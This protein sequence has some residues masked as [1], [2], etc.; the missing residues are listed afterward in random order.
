MSER[1]ERRERRGQAIKGTRSTSQCEAA[2]GRG[3]QDAGTACLPLHLA[4]LGRAHRW[5][6]QGFHRLTPAEV[7]GPPPF[8][9]LLWP[10]GVR[11]GVNRRDLLQPGR[12]RLPNCNSKPGHQRKG[13]HVHEAQGRRKTRRRAQTG[14]RKAHLVAKTLTLAALTRLSRGREGGEGW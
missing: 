9:R 12:Q 7:A 3:W 2:D 1:A 5:E 4:L 10:P 13:V 8:L 14:T 6:P 11:E